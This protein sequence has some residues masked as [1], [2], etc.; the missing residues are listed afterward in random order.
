MRRSSKKYIQLV[1][2]TSNEDVARS[3]KLIALELNVPIIVL[4]QLSRPLEE[5]EDKRPLLCD[6]R[7]NGSL[8]QNSDKVIFLYRENYYNQDCELNDIEL[9]VVKN[10]SGATGIVK[11][12]FDSDT[13]TFK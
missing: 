1:S 11:L 6:F 9:I 13:G 5:R 4:S 12:L 7:A 10:R 3:L 2:T 8:I